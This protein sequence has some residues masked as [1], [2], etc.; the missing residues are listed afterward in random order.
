MQRD[1]I[2]EQVRNTLVRIDSQENQEPEPDTETPIGEIQ[3]IYVL[4]VRER[5]EREDAPVV[6][7]STPVSSQKVSL[8]PAYTFCSIYLLCVLATL[9][10]QLYCIGNP[11]IATV[12]ILPKSQEVMLSGTVQ[13]GHLQSPITISQSQ[14]VATTGHGHQ[15]AEQARGY[16]TLYNGQFISQTIAAGTILTGTSGIQVVTDQDASIPAGNP[17]NYGQTTVASH[18][19]NPGA[20]GNIPAYAINQACCAQ[21]VL[22]KN[23]GAFS[24]GQDARTYHTVTQHDIHSISTV[25]KTTLSQSVKGALQGQVKSP[26]QLFILPCTPTVTSDHRIGDEATQVKV[27]VSQTC[28]AVAYNNQTLEGKATILLAARA[29]KTTGAGYSLFGTVN[30][31]MKQASVTGASHP[32]VFL[33][34]EAQGTWEYALDRPEQLHIQRLIAGMS[35]PKATQLVE[36]LP[37]VAHANIQFAGI[38]DPERVPKNTQDIH[39][40]LVVM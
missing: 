5:E 13:L 29:K 15:P 25:L 31:S 21:S 23:T 19:I 33:S 26:E 39:L 40:V 35:T 32:L 17:P 30:V 18:A 4:I 37:G 12:T 38:G 24:G 11:E 3:D 36:S 6:V 27:T 9:A 2:A 14:T 20:R 1:T 34:F 28:S 7:E 10:F 16:I 8:L 22:A